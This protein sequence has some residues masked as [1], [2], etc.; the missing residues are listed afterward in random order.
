MP[1]D[2]TTETIFH[3]S[4]HWALILEG[5]RQRLDYDEFKAREAEEEDAAAMEF[6]VAAIKAS[7]RLED[8]DPALNYTPGPNPPLIG[9]P[10]PAVPGFA[11]MPDLSYW[12]PPVVPDDDWSWPVIGSYIILPY[13]PIPSSIAV[14]SFQMATLFDADIIGTDME[15]FIDPAVFNAA[16]QTIAQFAQ[17]IAGPGGGALQAVEVIAWEQVE[18]ITTT[19]REFAAPL[20][21]GLVT[22]VLRDEEVSETFVNGI[23]A[24]EAPEFEDVL[25]QAIRAKRGLTDEPGEEPGEDGDNEEEAEAE[26]PVPDY[27]LNP[28]LDK[29]ETE[30]PDIFGVDP[31]HRV[32]TGM[33][34]ATNTVSLTTSMIDAGVIVVGG[35]VHTLTSVSQ[36]NIASNRDV[37]S[38]VEGPGVTSLNLAEFKILPDGLDDAEEDASGTEEGAEAG[39]SEGD[40]APSEGAELGPARENVQTSTDGRGGTATTS[41]G[42]AE[43]TVG[44]NV[45]VENSAAPEP[46]RSPVAEPASYQGLPKV[47]N[48]ET[49]EG[50]VVQLNSFSQVTFA[51]DTDRV[52][53]SIHAAATFIGT[54]ENILFNT[55]NAFEIGFGYDLIIVGGDFIDM[56]VVSQ[57][58]VL[59]DDD[60]VSVDGDVMVS[61]GDN[62][63]INQLSITRHGEDSFEDIEDHFENAVDK[64]ED[65][66]E[67]L[68]EAVAQDDLFFGIEALRAL[69]ITGD[70]VKVTAISQTN[71]MGDQDQVRLARDDFARDAGDMLEVVTGS[72]VLANRVTIEDLGFDSVIMASGDVYDDALLYTAELIDTDASPTGVDLTA[73]AS[74]A[75]AF[76]ADDMLLPDLREEDLVTPMETT[77]D[78]GDVLQSVLA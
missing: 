65:G 71:I 30:K 44:S 51:L 21:A 8:Y 58:N 46:D 26:E 60:N 45:S 36:V 24:D 70:L 15:G 5:L 56:T 37:G 16:L 68:D 61:S 57:I 35:N 7:F 9:A 52:D 25:P 55:M 32:V 59:L 43:A 77:T 41:D 18:D 39:E 74:E 64:L 54:G 73:L 22:T 75:V 11:E 19:V 2:R 50:D 69:Y 33:N 14:V 49:Y 62:L 13:V 29:D 66:V 42:T 27:K 28:V 31:G 53:F 63:L 76:L 23:Q 47:W 40:V 10:P 34:E 20:H 6:A 48:I 1:L 67:E 4:G 72:N 12:R 78:S 17:V 38:T 3:F